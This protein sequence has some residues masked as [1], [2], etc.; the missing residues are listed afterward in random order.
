[1]VDCGG[2]DVVE[3]DDDGVGV[4]SRGGVIFV[5]CGEWMCVI[6]VCSGGCGVCVGGVMV[7]C[8]VND[9]CVV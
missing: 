6:G 3:F 2:G 7:G 1:M 9:I 5:W 8:V 4:R